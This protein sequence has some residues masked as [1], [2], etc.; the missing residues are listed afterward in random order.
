MKLPSIRVPSAR[1]VITNYRS[2]GFAPHTDQRD[3]E[4][5]N[6]N[7]QEPLLAVQRVG[8]AIQHMVQY[9]NE[10]L[11]I[12]TLAAMTGFSPSHFFSLFKSATGFT[13]LAFFIG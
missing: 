2:V 9:L 6:R 13:P 4:N 11:R 1:E 5:H 7:L 12:S 10:P 8:L 3:G